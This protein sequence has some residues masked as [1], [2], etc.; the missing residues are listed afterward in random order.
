MNFRSRSGMTCRNP[1]ETSFME[2]CHSGGTPW[3][4]IIDAQGIFVFADFH[5]DVEQSLAAW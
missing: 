5:L 1:D 2:D 4:T 3:F